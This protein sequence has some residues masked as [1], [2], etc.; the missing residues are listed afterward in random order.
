MSILFTLA[1]NLSYTVF[2]T[3]P[4]LT[5]LLNLLKST[6]TVFNLST[7]ILSTS[8]FKLAKFDSSAKLEVSIPVASFKSA[9]VA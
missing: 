8:V 7:S 2:L 1:T 9:F 3:A 5:A 4:L 6:G